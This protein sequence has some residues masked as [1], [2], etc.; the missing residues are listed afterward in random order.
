M[1]AAE[2]A[3]QALV[4]ASAPAAKVSGFFGDIK[5]LERALGPKKAPFL[6]A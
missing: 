4:E 6:L 3:S 5:G 2:A 1:L